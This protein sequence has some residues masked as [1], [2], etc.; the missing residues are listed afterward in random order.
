[1]TTTIAPATTPGGYIIDPAIIEA[2][3]AD[4]ACV[5][6]EHKPGWYESVD[7]S[8]LDMASCTNCIL[9]QV[10]GGERDSIGEIPG[11]AFCHFFVSWLK[12]IL[13]DK[14]RGAA[15]AAKAAAPFWV[16]EI[17]ARTT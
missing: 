4:A 14:E 16:N 5:L 11:W 10:F 2:H 1:M 8:I 15:F 12:P 17:E 6:D 3:V 13:R 7:L 9:G